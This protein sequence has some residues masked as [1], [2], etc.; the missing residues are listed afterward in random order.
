M[1]LIA[2]FASVGGATAASRVLGFARE[3]AIAALLGAGPVADAFYAA[4]RFPNLFRR[5]FAEGPFNAAF[6]PLF[7]KALHGEDGRRAARELAS[8][9]G[10]LL[11]V[12]LVA[13]TALAIAF[14]PF[15][16][17]TVI[18][19]RFA[20]TPGKFAL[21]VEL[22]RIMFPY[23]AAMSFAA[24]LAG[25]L[26]AHSRYFVAAIAPTLLNVMLIGALTLAW[27]QGMDGAAIGRTM[28]WGVVL[29][30]ALQLLLLVLAIRRVGFSFSVLRLPKL[31]P[32]TR[33]FLVLAGPAVLTGGVT[34]I[35]LV[36]GQ[37][38]ASAQDGAI[39]LIN[40]ADRIFQLPFGIIGIAIGVVLLPELSRALRDGHMRT[41]AT[42]QN[43]SLEFAL[44]LTMPAAA[45]LIVMPEP[46][47]SVLFER[48]AF[49]AETTER[50][51]DVLRAFAWGLPAFVVVKVFQPAFY[52]R[53]DMRLPLY[54]TMA[55]VVVNIVLSLVLF[56]RMGPAGIG[57]ATS[58]AGWLNAMIL[59]A[60][61]TSRG[62]FLPEARTVRTICAIA[63]GA[64]LMG[65]L[66]WYASAS[67]AAVFGLG[68]VAKL[69]LVMFLVAAGAVVHFAVV[70]LV[71]G[72]G[73]AEL[74]GALRRG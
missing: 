25:V 6:V 32:G 71:G 53:E 11:F 8:D 9:I 28:A 66:L 38:I 72:V 43:R 51:A 45:G 18:A 70:A 5:L 21:T 67:F 49:T 41:A 22:A 14:M 15:L 2:K 69:L 50:T 36:I 20:D 48:G 65:A 30:G 1:S 4:F 31:S 17:G 13:V 19:P 52:A 26:N 58:A 7:T 62:L 12:L 74:R 59:F 56:P 3:A 33:R 64:V 23:L 24:M 16:T 40:Y 44:L 10:A 60:A 61:A 68:F 37:I 46:I 55:N 73:P 63:L 27:W 29:S 39:A 47:V 54:A 42:L 34:Q 35:N 57:M